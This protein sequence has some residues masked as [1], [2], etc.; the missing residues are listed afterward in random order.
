M[1]NRK[2]V[3]QVII[4]AGVEG[5]V[6]VQLELEVTNRK[7]AWQV[8]T[9]TYANHKQQS[10]CDI[11]TYTYTPHTHTNK[12]SEV[13]GQSSGVKSQRSKIK[14]QSSG[15]KGGWSWVLWKVV[16]KQLGVE[17][18]GMTNKENWTSNNDRDLSQ[19]KG[20]SF[21]NISIHPHVKIVL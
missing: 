10:F 12:R 20:Q 17:W 1:T 6:G 9:R 21:C 14:G 18:S 2:L 15:I 16:I 11:P 4:E 3:Q 7:L 19:S 13:K 8:M 5:M